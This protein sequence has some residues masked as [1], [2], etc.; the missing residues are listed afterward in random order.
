MPQLFSPPSNTTST[1]TTPTAVAIVTMNME[2]VMITMVHDGY[3]DDV[4]G[5]SEAGATGR[6]LAGVAA[7][8][9]ASSKSSSRTQFQ[10][11]SPTI[12]R[13]SPTTLLPH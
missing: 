1:L 10:L 9:V 12:T 5:R 8:L 3:D 11:F 4:M 13:S 7:P 6:A 2:A